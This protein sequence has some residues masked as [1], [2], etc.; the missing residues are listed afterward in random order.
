[1]FFDILWLS[2]FNSL[3]AQIVHGLR[4]VGQAQTG[5]RGQAS[6]KGNEKQATFDSAFYAA[7]LSVASVW[8]VSAWKTQGKNS[9]RVQYATTADLYYVNIRV[10]AVKTPGT[11]ISAPL[12]LEA[13]VA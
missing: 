8:R 5:A 11:Q 7:T 4:I 12:R 10:G 2:D 9:A 13:T 1:M 6:D 3:D